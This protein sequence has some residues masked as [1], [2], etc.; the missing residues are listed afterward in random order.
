LRN[1]RI[2]VVLTETNG[3][4]A[5]QVAESVCN[6]YLEQFKSVSHQVFVYPTVVDKD[7]DPA[8]DRFSLPSASSPGLT[9]NDIQ[10]LEPMFIQKLPLWKRLIDIFG[11]TV[12]LLLSAPL[13]FVAGLLIKFTSPGPLLFRQR[14]TGLGGKPFT[15]VKLRTMCVDAEAKKAALCQYSEQDGPAFKMEQDPRITNVG[16]FLRRTC[17]DE[18]PQLWNVLTGDMSLVGPRPLPCN[19]SDACRNWQRRRLDVTPGLTCDW[20]VNGGR[21]VTFAEWMRMDIR[22]IKAR[23]FMQD[24]KLL[25]KTAIAVLFRRASC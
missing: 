18:L 11:A 15:I 9:S 3:V 24:V 5:H 14:R 7:A 13:L 6:Q 20:Q 1:D 8:N 10:P 21:R 16:R 22:Y 19:E 12:G 23:T 17:I 4:G 25:G 2:G